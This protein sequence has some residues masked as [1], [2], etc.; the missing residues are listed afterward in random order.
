MENTVFA[1][2][3]PKILYSKREAAQVLS[4]SLRTF[5]NLIANEE[6][7]VRRLGRR[8]L[9]EFRELQRFAQQD[10]PTQSKETESA[11]SAT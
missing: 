9:V 11:R 5:D 6:I 3:V 1:G 4:V 7:V 2:P 10:H 8:V